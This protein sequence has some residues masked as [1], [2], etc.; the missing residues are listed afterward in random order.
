MVM[1]DSKNMPQDDAEPK[2]WRN[3]GLMPLSRE[4]MREFAVLQG[5]L[6]PDALLADIYRRNA[7]DFSER[8]Q[9]LIELC[10]DWREHHCIRSHYEQVETN[11]ATKLKPNT[12]RKER[13]EL[14]QEKAIEGASR[15]ALA[16]MLTRRLTLRHS[17]DS[18]SANASEAALDVSKVL[19]DWSA[20]TRTTLLVH[21]AGSG[22]P[23]DR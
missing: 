2:V 14:S 9:D 6:D 12:E 18:D 13:T 22:D 5:V 10:S 17:A 19:P 8:P 16:A 20:E 4:Q 1:A 11:V 7:E 21:L 15:L 3:V 23:V